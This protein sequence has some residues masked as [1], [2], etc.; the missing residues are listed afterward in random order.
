M[1]IIIAIN[2]RSKRFWETKKY[3]ETLGISIS[4]KLYR[5]V[6]KKPLFGLWVYF[7]SPVI[8][9]RVKA[10]KFECLTLESATCFLKT[11]SI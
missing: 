10:S 8:I 4:F 7:S 2:H 3:P 1:L 6:L 5:I 11:V 9:N